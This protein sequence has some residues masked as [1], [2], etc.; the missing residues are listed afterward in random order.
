MLTMKQQPLY[1]EDWIGLKP[2]DEAAKVFFESFPGE[3]M[4]LPTECWEWIVKKWVGR[5]HI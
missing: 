1:M 2:L 5:K 3:H 4:Q